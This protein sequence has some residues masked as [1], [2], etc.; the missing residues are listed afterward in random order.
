M[1]GRRALARSREFDP[2]PFNERGNSPQSRFIEDPLPHNSHTA[3]GKHF[4]C[5][6]VIRGALTYLRSLT[7]PGIYV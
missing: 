7:V 5:V 2:L 3:R 4:C 6:F 1:P